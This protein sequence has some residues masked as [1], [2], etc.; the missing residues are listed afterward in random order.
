ML[1]ILK[2]KIAKKQ[3]CK[4]VDFQITKSTICRTDQKIRG[5]FMD[6]TLVSQPKP[7]KTNAYLEC[8]IWVLQAI[9]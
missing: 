3:L 8:F 4:F 7:Q 2:F 9:P 1:Q 6:P 5:R